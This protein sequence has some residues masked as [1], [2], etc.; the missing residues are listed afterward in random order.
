MTVAPSCGN[1]RY[2]TASARKASEH[3]STPDTRTRRGSPNSDGE[4]TASSVPGA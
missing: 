1:A 4:V 3:F 2:D